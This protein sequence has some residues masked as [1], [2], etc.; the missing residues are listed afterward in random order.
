ME[1][2]ERPDRARP[3]AL[4]AM[5]LEGLKQELSMHLARAMQRQNPV[6]IYNSFK[7][8]HGF[9]GHLEP[10]ESIQA[11]FPISLSGTI[12]DI[13]TYLDKENKDVTVYLKIE[14]PDGSYQFEVP[15]KKGFIESAKT[16][17][18]KR[19][20]VVFVKIVNLGQV[21]VDASVGFTF[22]EARINESY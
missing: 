11:S 21:S 7:I 4:R 9:G 15:L 17:G 22:Q 13:F 18:V 1:S 12:Q 3:V 10:G 16:S 6:K 14:G 8:P 2:S 20:S 5:D 19:P